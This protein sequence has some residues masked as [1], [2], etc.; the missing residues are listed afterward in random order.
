LKNRNLIIIITLLPTL[1]FANAGSPMMWFGILHSLFLNSIIGVFESKYLEKRKVENKMWIIILGNY[2]SMI[3]GLNYI[4]P[5]FSSLYGNLD[6]WGGNT[7]YGDYEL[8]GFIIG[9]FASFLATLFLELP[10]YYFSLKDKLNW[11][12]GI[13]KFVEANTISNLIMFLIYYYIVVNGSK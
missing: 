11:K 12:K 7:N 1:A 10:F 8:N 2:F 6:F 5:Y 4:A 13:L 9:M 3:I